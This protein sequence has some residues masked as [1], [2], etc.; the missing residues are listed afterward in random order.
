LLWRNMMMFFVFSTFFYTKLLHHGCHSVFNWHKSVNLFNQ[1]LLIFPFHQELA[2]WC[3]VLA[4]VAAKQLICF[5]SLARDNFNCLKVLYDYLHKRSGQCFSLIQERDIP[6]QTNSC[7]VS[8]YV[9]TLL[10]RK[11][12]LLFLTNRHSSY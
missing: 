7:G 3:L 10:S 5:D 9:C 6:R 11:V 2:H 4:D 1:R 12:C 8:L